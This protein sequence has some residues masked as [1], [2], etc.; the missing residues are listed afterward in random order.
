MNRTPYVSHPSIPNVICTRQHQRNS[1]YLCLHLLLSGVSI[2]T[3][4]LGF[5][6]FEPIS[7]FDTAA[8][9]VAMTGETEAVCFHQ[10]M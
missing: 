7:S 3:M 6:W 10:F 8:L 9:V 4:N 1:R 2:Q 5:I